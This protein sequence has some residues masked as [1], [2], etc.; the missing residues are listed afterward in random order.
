MYKIYHRIFVTMVYKMQKYYN[1]ARF[2]FDG[3]KSSRVKQYT[4]KTKA[5]INFKL[6]K[7]LKN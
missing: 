4:L 3:E 1:L 2:V 6:H 7:F 5:K